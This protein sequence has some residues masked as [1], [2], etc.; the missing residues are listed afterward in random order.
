MS[1]L[2]NS[3]FFPSGILEIIVTISNVSSLNALSNINVQLFNTTLLCP[4]SINASN[5][6][7]KSPNL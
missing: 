7:I 5:I 3:T 6:L 2:S 1:L 4:F